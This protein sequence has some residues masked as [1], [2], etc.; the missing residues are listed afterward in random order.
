MSGSMK[1]PFLEKRDGAYYFDILGHKSSKTTEIYTRVAAENMREISSPLYD[2]FGQKG[3]GFWGL[4]WK[5]YKTSECSSR[6]GKTLIIQPV[7][8]KMTLASCAD[9]TPTLGSYPETINT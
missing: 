6:Q 3:R 1:A 9:K 4:M 7:T 8:D 2:I 5:P